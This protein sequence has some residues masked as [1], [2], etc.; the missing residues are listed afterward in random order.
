MNT[1]GHPQ[2]QPKDRPDHPAYRA[3]LEEIKD[4]PIEHGK[5]LFREVCERDFPFFVLHA[6]TFGRYL[7]H[8]PGHPHYGKPW[9]TWPWQWQRL[10]EFHRL[11]T[12]REKNVFV[13]HPRGHHKTA[14]LTEAGST[15]L[16]IRN[17][18]ITILCVTWKSDQTGS[19]IH[20]SIRSEWEKNE[21]LQA[22]WGHIFSPEA[23]ARYTD[24]HLTVAREN[25]PREPTF[26]VAGIDGSPVSQHFDW[27]VVDDVVVRDTVK[28]PE[29]ILSTSE[30]LD[31]LVALSGQEAW[32]TYV[33]TIWKL[34]DPWMRMIREDKVERRHWACYH[35]ATGVSKDRWDRERPVL[36]TKDHLETLR[37][38]AGSYRFSA[39]YL[40]EPLPDEDQDLQ[41]SWLKYYETSD[42][43]EDRLREA[44]GKHCYL[45]FDTS[46]GRNKRSDFGAFC[47]VGLDKSQNVYLLDLWRDRLS[48][49]ETVDLVFELNETWPLRMTFID[50]YRGSQPYLDAI[51][52]RQKRDGWRFPLKML[53]SVNDSKEERISFLVPLL[54]AGRFWLP[55]SGFGRGS[56]KDKRDLL[57]QFK[58]DEYSLWKASGE[59][60]GFDDILDCLAWINHPETKRFFRSPRRPGD[61]PG[62]ARWKKAAPTDRFAVGG[63]VG[64]PVDRTGLPAGVSS[65]AL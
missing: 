48:I 51:V 33:G 40:G 61:T 58:E 31:D 15:W 53:P 47:V 60:G 13:N 12:L 62:H 26:Q 55:S 4:A 57:A 37:K 44:T 22:H 52:D 28:T 35:P 6:H 20:R 3:I 59:S 41:L 9:A 27:I 8:Q 23:G 25:G 30:A 5:Q 18:Q 56:R 1:A 7:C 50:G 2:W 42:S 45:I 19:A 64:Y 17:Q 43:R 46:E 65:W 54:E 16:P 21:V 29:R 49:I 39:H 11:L 38:A 10:L 24:K 36:F 32:I 14:T 34:D 63:D